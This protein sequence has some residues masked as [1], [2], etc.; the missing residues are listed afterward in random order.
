MAH[1][2]NL[3]DDAIS[4]CPRQLSYKVRLIS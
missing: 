2:L 1:N 4:L 3:G